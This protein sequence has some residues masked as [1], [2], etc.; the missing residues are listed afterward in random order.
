MQAALRS[1]NS[2]SPAWRP[3]NSS[4]ARRSRPT[5]IALYGDAL[6][7]SGLFEEAEARYRDAL[8]VAPDL[9]RGHHG[10]AR[11]LAARSRLH[12]GDG[13]SADRAAARAARSRDSPHGRRDL[14][15]DAQVRG[16][17]GR[18]QQLRQPAAEQ[19]S[20]RESRLVAVGDQVPAVVRTAGAVR[21]GHRAR[22]FSCTRSIFDWS[23]TRSS[24]A[25]K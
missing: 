20:Q 6:W 5:A 7:A 10:M 17:G 14:R 3:K 23:T 11:A 18:L 1:P 21:N 16:S 24:S 15:A 4:P 9:A 13:R 12:R 22:R 8:S 25:R 19:G 2:I